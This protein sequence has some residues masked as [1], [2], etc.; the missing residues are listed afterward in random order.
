MVKNP[1]DIILFSGKTDTHLKAQKYIGNK[2]SQV[3]ILMFWNGELAILEST[4]VPICNDMENKKLVRGVQVVS[5]N[6]KISAFDGEV[7]IRTLKPQLCIK[8]EEEL[9]KFAN[10]VKGKPFNDSKYFMA[11][12]KK[13]RNVQNESLSY[14]CS[15]L[16]AE[17]LQEL[18]ILGKPPLNFSSGNY[19]PSDFCS[20]SE[21]KP[22]D[23]FVFSIEKI[24]KS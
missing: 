10:R 17:S 4:K 12:A 24:I 14:F 8:Q 19:S 3:G 7:A 20:D 9:F 22:I 21:I 18:G 16:V 6:E 13:R 5:F 2:W 11:R 23:P 15:Q 1:G